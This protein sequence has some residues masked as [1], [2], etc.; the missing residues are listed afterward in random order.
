MQ[1]SRLRRH[2]I[3]LRISFP[4]FLPYVQPK[5]CRVIEVCSTVQAYYSRLTEGV[6]ALCTVSDNYMRTSSDALFPSTLCGANTGT[7]ASPRACTMVAH[8]LTV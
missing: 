6:T 7:Y 8:D 5:A 4:L 1:D 2:C 3:R